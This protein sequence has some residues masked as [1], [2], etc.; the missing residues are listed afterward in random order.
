MP[1]TPSLS[2][3]PLSSCLQL[4]HLQISYASHP[5]QEEDLSGFN[6]NCLQF[7]EKTLTVSAYSSVHL[8]LLRFQPRCWAF[9][10]SLAFSS[11]ASSCTTFH[12]SE[13]ITPGRIYATCQLNQSLLTFSKFHMC[14]L[15][16]LSHFSRVRLCATP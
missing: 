6:V 5:F 14:A 13:E 9:P 3:C 4:T 15:L 2:G 10:S 7:S 8:L 11:P 1:V 12:Q 16:L